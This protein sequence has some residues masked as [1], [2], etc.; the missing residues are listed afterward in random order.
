MS[1][2][3]R[4]AAFAL[5][6]VVLLL[7]LAPADLR[8]PVRGDEPD[9]NGALNQ[10]ARMEA[11][12]ARQRAQLADLLRDQAALTASLEQLSKDLTAVGL[13]LQA[14][15]EQLE[16]VTRQLER[17]RRD[18]ERYQ[19]RIA[20]LEQDL[21]A[22]ATDIQVSIRDLAAR[23]ALLEDHLRSA[24]EQSQTSVLEILL[25][26]ESFDQA[27]GQLSYLLTLSDE[28]RRLAADIRD[29]REQLR[30]RQQTLREGRTTLGQLRDAEAARVAALDEQQRQVDAARAQ[31]VEY[32]RQ[33]EELQDK[34]AHD[35]ASTIQN[36]EQTEEAIAA[37]ERALEGQQALVERLKEE[38]DRLDLAYR[39]RF[40]WPEQGEFVVTQEFGRTSFNPS[41]T[42]IDLA[43]RSP[44]CGGPIYAAADGVVLA[45]G[46]PNAGYGDTAIGV[47]VGHSQRLQTWYWHLSREL[48]SVGQEVKTGDLLGYEGAT[49]L[50]TGCHLHFEVLLDGDPVS[51]RQYLP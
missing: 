39:G 16:R 23:E 2:V 33:L 10:Q 37:H 12:L 40:A 6:L 32:Q 30:V 42:G 46:R 26:T 45:D 8:P 43:Y 47:V 13:E 27:S 14:A 20:T 24:Y 18:L 19:S 41:H 36:A 51:P 44:R 29:A 50:A 38:A 48:V 3:R 7:M 49:G 4:R 17:S 22:V 25:S 1:I 21:D 15:V 34:H 35:L 28:D 11:E 5:A 31:L 9:V